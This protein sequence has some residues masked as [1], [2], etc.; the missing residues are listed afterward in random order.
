M[1]LLVLFFIFIIS[2]LCVA[3]MLLQKYVNTYN[4]LHARESNEVAE[5]NGR[6]QLQKNQTELHKLE[7]EIRAVIN[8]RLLEIDQKFPDLKEQGDEEV[9]EILI[10]KWRRM[11]QSSLHVLKTRSQNAE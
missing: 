10:K 4:Q 5:K 3:V 9:V 11:F 8:K 1:I 7:N 2:L 6:L